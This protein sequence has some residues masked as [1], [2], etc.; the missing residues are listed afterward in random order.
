MDLI[1]L[2]GWPAAN[3]VSTVQ[4][5]QFEFFPNENPP[6]RARRLP[7]S[8]LKHVQLV[9]QLF[10]CCDID[11]HFISKLIEVNQRKDDKQSAEG[12]N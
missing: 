4:L 9:E 10:S 2:F 7:N 5:T 11:F 6:T 8:A 3:N 1:T 12:L